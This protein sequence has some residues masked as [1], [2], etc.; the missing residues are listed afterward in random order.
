MLLSRNWLNFW[1]P[2]RSS[3]WQLGLRVQSRETE[4]V[5]KCFYFMIFFPHLAMKWNM[6]RGGGGVGWDYKYCNNDGNAFIPGVGMQFGLVV[7][8]WGREGDED[9][10]RLMKPG[11]WFCVQ[12]LLRNLSSLCLLSLPSRKLSY[13]FFSHFLLCVAQLEIRRERMFLGL[14]LKT[15]APPQWQGK[16]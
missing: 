6:Q 14:S 1:K 12:S 13:L 2:S 11:V 7:E 3:C 8:G 9:S 10:E 16:D 5:G 4:H 15:T